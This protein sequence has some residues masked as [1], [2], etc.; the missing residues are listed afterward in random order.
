MSFV[1]R[2]AIYIAVV[3]AF[4]QVLPTVVMAGMSAAFLAGV[5]A[6]TLFM[7]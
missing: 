4:F 1:F 6:R 5:S 3:I 7:P 2:L